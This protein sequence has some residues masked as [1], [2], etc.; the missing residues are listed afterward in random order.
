MQQFN[1]NQM[2]QQNPNAMMQQQQMQGVPGNIQPQMNVANP[3]QNQQMNFM[4]P[5]GAQGMQQSGMNPQ[6]QWQGQNQFH[7]IQQQQQ[8]QQF[9]QQQQGMQSNVILI[10]SLNSSLASLIWALY[11]ITHS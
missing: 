1:P 2:L 9:Y 10:I 4:G 6:Q 5:G 11:R 3:Q 8:Q 7:P